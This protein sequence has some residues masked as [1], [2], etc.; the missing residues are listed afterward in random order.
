[1]TVLIITAILIL[2]PI[3]YVL[4]S[5]SMDKPSTLDDY[6]VA[7]HRI[8]PINFI[9][10]SVAYGLQ[11]A[12]LTLFAT[13][14]YQYGIWVIWVPLFWLL[15]YVLLGW[16]IKRGV[17]DDI[18]VSDDT[19]T[20][21]G[22]IGSRLSRSLTYVASI[23]SL[24]AIIGTAMYEADFA[25]SF[26][27]EILF[28]AANYEASDQAV[29]NLKTALFAL[30]VLVAA[31]YMIVA[32]FKAVVFT[33]TIQLFIGLV[34]FSAVISLLAIKLSF[35]GFLASS[36]SLL[37]AATILLV[38]LSYYWHLQNIP[39]SHVVA[40]IRVNWLFPALLVVFVIG[41]GVSLV[42][43]Y[44]DVSKQA[45]D[46]FQLNTPFNLGY[47]L[48]FNLLVANVFY[49]L[50]DV[51]QY[52]RLISVETNHSEL[53]QTRSLLANANL[54]VG[55]YSAFSWVLAIF[56]GILLKMYFF[57]AE[58][59]AYSII[60][61][62]AV[63]LLD[64]GVLGITIV[65]LLLITILSLAFSSL[66]SYIA[67]IS[68]TVDKDIASRIVKGTSLIR[69]RVTT[70]LL[71]IAGFVLI[72]YLFPYLKQKHGIEYAAEFL[73]LC[74]AF[75][76]SLLPLVLG[77]LFRVRLSGIEYFLALAAGMTGALIPFF[78]DVYLVYES[79]AWGAALGSMGVF[80]TFILIR[81]FASTW[82]KRG[83]ES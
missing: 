66:D 61:E 13:W 64:D 35:V 59:D 57:S 34:A 71:M 83:I 7:S 1:M 21:H 63:S 65:S 11:V 25:G 42:I 48:L 24:I 54:T 9:N 82:A 14:G 28:K 53:E 62:F 40:G 31:S 55:L 26:A 69:P 50:V 38:A 5:F 33:D 29:F 45:A 18:I 44:N 49:Q 20:V 68:F 4:L 75:Q 77:A 22:F 80:A 52:Q 58:V 47:G 10:S 67:G 16:L 78:K 2:I 56:F 6:H 81:K 79:S 41:I 46:P 32:G 36:L 23:I 8:K 70:A 43:G 51:G 74:W 76:I 37:I 39:G 72:S 27:T 19:D 60:I 15:G 30:I 73:Y 17:L 3:K 12:A